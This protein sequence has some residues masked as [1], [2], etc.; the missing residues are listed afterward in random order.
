MKRKLLTSSY[1]IR[2]QNECIFFVHLQ[3]PTWSHL[4]FFGLDGMWN[5]EW[6]KKEAKIKQQ[7]NVRGRIRLTAKWSVQPVSQVWVFNTALQF[8]KFQSAKGELKQSIRWNKVW[9]APP[10]LPPKHPQTSPCCLSKAGRWQPTAPAVPWRRNHDGSENKHRMASL[11]LTP[12]TVKS[13][14]MT[15]R[16]IS[17]N[18]LC[19]ISI[20]IE[21]KLLNIIF[22]QSILHHIASIHLSSIP[23]FSCI[24]GP[25]GLFEPNP[26]VTGWRRASTLNNSPGNHLYSYEH[27]CRQFRLPFFFTCIFTLWEELSRITQ[28]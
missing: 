28:T 4:W 8:I 15:K 17:L 1:F 18:I 5:V 11:E 6:Q 7:Y 25:R 12:E 27:T 9:V 26:A 21:L 19:Q 23:T 2:R 13:I 3:L 10:C 22:M 20:K 16:R 14:G 24:Q